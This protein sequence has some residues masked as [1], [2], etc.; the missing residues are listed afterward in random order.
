[1]IIRNQATSTLVADI[2]RSSI[3]ALDCIDTDLIRLTTSAIVIAFRFY[4]AIVLDKFKNKVIDI[5]GLS[6]QLVSNS[7]RN[8]DSE[9]IPD[10]NDPCIQQYVLKL[11][12]S[13]EFPEF[14]KA[15]KEFLANL[16]GGNL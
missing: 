1:M 6:C 15:L 14:T 8:I 12:M 13:P 7:N 5:L 16:S 9:L 2:P 10:L 4:D 11:L 3:H